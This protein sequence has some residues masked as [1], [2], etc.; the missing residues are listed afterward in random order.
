LEQL[1]HRVFFLKPGENWESVVPSKLY[2]SDVVV[3]LL[4]R[5]S[6]EDP[7]TTLEWGMA[8]GIQRFHGRGTIIPVL[9]EREAKLVEP[10]RADYR[11]I[12]GVGRSDKQIADEIHEAIHK[13][14]PLPKIF[15]SHSHSDRELA[16]AL[17]EVLDRA[18][19]LQP[20]D[21]RATSLAGSGL[22]VGADVSNRLRQDLEESKVVLGVVTGTSLHSAY[23]LFELG[24]S[25]GLQ[26]PTYPLLAKGAGVKDLPGPLKELHAI[27][28]ANAPSCQQLIEQLQ[29]DAGLKRR[30]ADG[31]AETVADAITRLNKIAAGTRMSRTSRPAQGG[32]RRSSGREQ[33]RRRA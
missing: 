4:T 14:V 8:V 30:E 27:D 26:K 19:E 31:V 28:L 7:W 23:V 10:L 2:D 13:H 22:P 1:G 29:T 25:W 24:A 11:S 32:R 18:L 3:A 33:K 17:K 16:G 9:L 20:R 21:I 6:V 15:V 5:R 12:D